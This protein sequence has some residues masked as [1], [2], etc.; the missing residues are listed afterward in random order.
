MTIVKRQGVKPVKEY[1]QE[2]KS[3][4]VMKKSD[5]QDIEVYVDLNKSSVHLKQKYIERL[6]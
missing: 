3:L 5:V 6:K 4:S 1:H 2:K